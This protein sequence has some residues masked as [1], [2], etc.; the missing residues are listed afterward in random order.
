LLNSHHDT[1]KPNEHYTRDPFLATITDDKLYGLGSND[2]GGCVV[3]L[4]AAFM[5][6]YE[7]AGMPYNLLLAISAE[8]EISGSNGIAA[9][10]TDETL[11]QALQGSPLT[12]GIVGEPTLMQ[13][14]VAERGLM[15]LDVIANGVAGHAARNEGDNAIYKALEDMAWLR[16]HRFEK[17]SELLGPVQ[18]NVTVINTENRMHNTVPASC[19]FVVDVRINECYT[20]EEVLAEI[21]AAV[22]SRVEPRSMRMRSS[23]IAADHPLVQAGIAMGKACYGSPTS[24]DKA[25]LPFPALKMGPGDSAR[26]H[27][28][29]EFI[30]TAEIEEGIAGYIQLLSQVL[31]K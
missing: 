15:V 11:L 9:L 13:L 5:H 30:Y 12:A 23:C 27:T 18:M 4:I 7:Q 25:F 31:N 8:E 16:D 3:A 29:D 17:I 14:A 6:F 1:V 24:S 10:L 26:S 21:R 20:H 28:A 19:H 22:K 2:A